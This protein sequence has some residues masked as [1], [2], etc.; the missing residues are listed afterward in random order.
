MAQGLQIS[1]QITFSADGTTMQVQVSVSD[2]TT[3][4]LTASGTIPVTS[5]PL[6]PRP[7]AAPR[8]LQVHRRLRTPS[9]GD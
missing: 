5:T 1:Q 7:S 4:T 3:G 8:P 9:H 2:P 6:L